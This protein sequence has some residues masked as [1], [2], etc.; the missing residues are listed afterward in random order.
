MCF[1]Y[2]FTTISRGVYEKYYTTSKR[3]KSCLTQKEVWKYVDRKVVYS[4][5][6]QP[7]FMLFIWFLKVIHKVTTVTYMWCIRLALN[8]AVS[9]CR[10]LLYVF[11]LQNDSLLCGLLVKTYGKQVCLRQIVCEM[12]QKLSF[13]N[14]EFEN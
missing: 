14:F 11:F 1:L 5:T 10:H 13:A 4:R 8:A 2:Y 3:T 6:I 12:Y 9:R 7:L